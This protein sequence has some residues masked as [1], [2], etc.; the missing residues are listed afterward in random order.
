MLGVYVHIPFC[1]KIC[2]Y[3][4]FCKILY[5]SKYVDKYLD[6]LEEEINSRY[7]GEIV[8]TIYIGGGTPSSLNEEQLDKLLSILTIFNL[9]DNYEYTIECNIESIDINKINI[10]KSYGI[11]R[12]SFGVESFNKDIQEIL[13]RSH[14]EDM[15]FDN[16]YMTKKYFDNINIDLIYGVNNNIE[17]VKEDIRKFLE[18]DIPHISC[19]SLILE[20]NTKLYID[21]HKYID[22]EIDREM[23]EYISN[24]LKKNG[25]E[26]Y[27][28]S[29]YAKKGYKSIH[30]K[31]YWLNG[32]YYGFGL[33]AVSFIEN[34]RI[35]NTKNMSKYLSGNYVNTKENEDERVR[36]ENDL[37]LGFRMI[38]GIN[39]NN[40]NL[41]YN[42]NL[43]DKDVIKELINDGYLE[44]VDGY[45]R[46]N[47]KYIYLENYIL[48]KIIG[49]DL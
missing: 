14:D 10:F 6:K 7:K 8:N 39:I 19:Y 27:E 33:G 20:E 34:Y 47:Y 23:F 3:C 25:Y 37:I 18:L 43:L 41:K 2:N 32:S 22:E 17:L 45:I 49:S 13:G 40:F 4:D 28:I 12:I 42:D 36:K 30:N 24:T 48:E 46:C 1:N 11:N 16:I 44:V 21:K 29:N 26:H 31:N 35:S 38:N 9:S 5:N 15:I